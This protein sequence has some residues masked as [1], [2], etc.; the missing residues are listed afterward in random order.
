MSLQEQK[1]LGLTVHSPWAELI[2]RGI[3][4]VENRSWA[5]YEWMLGRYIAIHASTRWDQEGVDFINRNH[6]RFQVETPQLQECVYGVVAVARLVGWVV[7]GP[8]SD[9]QKPVTVKM[10][11]GYE[12]GSN[13]N[14]AGR[15]LDWSWFTG[16]FGW[17]LRDTVRIAPVAC[18]G[19]QKLWALPPPVYKSVRQRFDVA[20]KAAA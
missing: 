10:L 4:T 17:V 2:A 5:P 12:F 7:R 13:V 18:R 8:E 6:T 20:R 11:P 9:G 19:M 14:A 16:P 15:S 1:I 3:K